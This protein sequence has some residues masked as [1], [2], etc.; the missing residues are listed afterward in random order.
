MK[1]FTVKMYYIVIAALLLAVSFFAQAIQP[2]AA[3]PFGEGL[4]GIGKFGAATSLVVSLGGNV[5]FYA[6]NLGFPTIKGYGS[7]TIT[8]TSTDV[9]GYSIYAYCPSG[10]SMTNG[11]NTLAASTNTTASAL[12]NNTWGFNMSATDHTNY[13]GMTS[14]PQLV[15]SATGIYSSGDSTIM[16]YGI[17]TDF[18]KPPG[19]YSVNV[20]YT[21]VGLN[22]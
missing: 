17:L 7:H 10:T 8:V 16:Q 19:S 11:S 14:I 12:S 3:S 2:V 15:K 20:V 5:S 21:V 22:D 13:I 9:V 1:L 18:Q 4:F 6:D